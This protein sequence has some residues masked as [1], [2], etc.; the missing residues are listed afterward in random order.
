M[1]SLV[2]HCQ[3]TGH[4]PNG[5]QGRQQNNNRAAKVQSEVRT[6]EDEAEVGEEGEDVDVEVEDG[7]QDGEDAA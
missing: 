6:E 3:T 7:A 4:R 1:S 5:T 2:R